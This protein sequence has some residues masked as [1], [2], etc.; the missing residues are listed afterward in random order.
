[1][2]SEISINGVG[3]VNPFET[4]TDAELTKKLTNDME[5]WEHLLTL[6]EEANDVEMEE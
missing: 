1:M 5:E 4:A 6:D 2:S 3:I